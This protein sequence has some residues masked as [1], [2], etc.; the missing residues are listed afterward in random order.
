MP[1]HVRVLLV[2][3]LGKSEEPLLER[4]EGEEMEM[5]SVDRHRWVIILE[6][7]GLSTVVY[8][9]DMHFDKIEWRERETDRETQ[10]EN[11]RDK[12]V[13]ERRKEEEKYLEK[14]QE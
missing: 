2:S 1:S 4:K 14:D 9:A 10:A 3:S 5:L 7:G 6:S 13:R 8:R 11:Y 12:T